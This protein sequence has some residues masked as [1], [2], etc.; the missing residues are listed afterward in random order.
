MFAHKGRKAL[1]HGQVRQTWFI[2]ESEDFGVKHR[3]VGK[4]KSKNSVMLHPVKDLARTGSVEDF[5]Q[6]HPTSLNGHHGQSV[7]MFCYG[8]M[9]GGVHRPKRPFITSQEAIGTKYSQGVLFAPK[10]RLANGTNPSSSKIANA[11]KRVVHLLASNVHGHAVKGEI[12]PTQIFLQRQ[13]PLHMFRSA[14]VSVKRF[15]PKCGHLVVPALAFDGDRTKFNPRGYGAV[16]KEREQSVRRACGAHINIGGRCSQPCI[17]NTATHQPSALTVLGDGFEQRDEVV[18]EGS[19]PANQLRW[20][21]QPI[22]VGLE[23]FG[24]C[25]TF[26]HAPPLLVLLC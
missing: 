15:S 20:T 21:R 25:R 4:D 13:A 3:N 1:V 7:S 9:E 14:P 12:T 10:A 26:H 2:E 19:E 22:K 16:P 17:T 18:V 6:L 8:V 24:Q 5:P 23:A 11:I